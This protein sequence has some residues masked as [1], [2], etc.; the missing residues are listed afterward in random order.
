MGRLIKFLLI[1]IL[2]AFFANW[3]PAQEGFAVKAIEFKGND[4]LSGELL[5][6]QMNTRAA[7]LLEKLT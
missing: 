4:N 1:M 3:V 6:E 5:S 7:T 2:S